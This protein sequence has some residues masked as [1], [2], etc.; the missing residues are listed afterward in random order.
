MVLF[1]K[2]W[3]CQV[4]IKKE[5]S[6]REANASR[7]RRLLLALCKEDW[8]EFDNMNQ[9]NSDRMSQAGVRFGKRTI[10]GN[11]KVV[12]VGLANRAGAG[13]PEPSSLID[14]YA[15]TMWSHSILRILKFV[16]TSMISCYCATHLRIVVL[17][18]MVAM[19]S[20]GHQYWLSVIGLR[21]EFILS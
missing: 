9:G 17:G 3:H 4:L 12:R 13:P 1:P 21:S 2:G 10:I 5:A 20:V 19:W 6:E 18:S 8:R 11:D 15:K 7:I 14:L 16:W